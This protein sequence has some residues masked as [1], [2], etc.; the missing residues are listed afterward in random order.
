MG[1]DTIE[2]SKVET[3]R[4]IININKNVG[5]EYTVLRKRWEDKL[6][7]KVSIPQYIFTKPLGYT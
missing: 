1:I 3:E 6:S 2:L 7:R 4:E 5:Q